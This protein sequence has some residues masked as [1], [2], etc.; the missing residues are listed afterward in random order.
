MKKRGS[1]KS[2]KY[3]SKES[4]TSSSSSSSDSDSE[5]E[6]VNVISHMWDYSKDED[7][8]NIN[9]AEYKKVE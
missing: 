3:E 2:K 9:E 6:S 1:K 7:E 8:S 4:D 5:W